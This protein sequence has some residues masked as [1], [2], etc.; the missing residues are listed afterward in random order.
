MGIDIHALNFLRFACN[1]QPFGTV[2]TIG[3]QALLVDPWTLKQQMAFPQQRDFGPFC[4]QLLI[5]CF[6]ATGVESYDNSTY[7][8]ATYIQ[9]MNCELNS[10]RLYETVFDGGCLEHIFNVPQALYNVS[11][12][13]APGGQ[14]LHV[15]PGNNF[16][17][18][19]FWQ[20]SPELFFSLYSVNNGYGETQVFIADLLDTEYWYEVKKPQDGMR[21]NVSSAT[22]LYVLVRTKRVSDQFVHSKVQQSDYVQLWD[23]AQLPGT[24]PS[25]AD[26][27]LVQA[28]RHSPFAPIAKQIYRKG[29]RWAAGLGSVMGRIPDLIRDSVSSLL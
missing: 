16:C 24:K 11:A 5:Q 3:R 18:H 14:I 10:V 27:G 20:F 7:E 13:C 19:G 12:M 21:A 29:K 22:S 15:L 8:G 6:G 9:D 1:T 25:S 28:I 4:E 26:S 17:G 23:G 2:A